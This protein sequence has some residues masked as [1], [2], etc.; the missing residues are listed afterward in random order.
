MP[1]LP[2]LERKSFRSALVQV[3]KAVGRRLL[4]RATHQCSISS[5]CVFKQRLCASGVD[6][7]SLRLASTFVLLS[8]SCKDSV[9]E[10]NLCARLLQLSMYDETRYKPSEGSRLESVC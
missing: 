6:V 5:T 1:M 4:P 3:V 10:R 9:G 2:G 8:L 7:A